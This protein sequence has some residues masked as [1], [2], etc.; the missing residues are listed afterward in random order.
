MAALAGLYG[1]RGAQ[2]LKAGC[3]AILDA[4]TPYGD[5]D[6]HIAAFEEVSLGLAS[7]EETPGGQPMFAADRWL[8]VADVRL[9]NRQDLEQRLDLEPTGSLSDREIIFQCWLRWGDR[10]AEYVSGEYAL[11]AFDRVE[12]KLVLAR[13]PTGQRPLYFI[14]RNGVIALASMPSGLAAIIGD[15]QPNIAQLVHDVALIPSE[16]D[17]TV[18][19]DIQRLL[20]AETIVFQRGSTSRREWSPRTQAILSGADD[21]FVEQFRFHLDEA[22]R[23]RLPRATTA[24][25]LSAGWDSNAVTATAAR[26]LKDPSGL[27]ALTSAPMAGPLGQLPRG[28]FADEAEMAGIAARYYGVRHVVVRETESD[29]SVMRRFT[30]LCQMPVHSPTQ[31]AWWSRLRHVARDSGASTILTGELGNWT[32]NFGGLA[33]LGDLARRGEWHR[34]WLEARKAARRHDVRWRGILINSFGYRLPD[35]L[36]DLLVRHFQRFEAASAVKFL[37]PEWRS[38]LHNSLAARVRANG[39]TAKDRWRQIKANDIGPWR[40]AGLA[41]CGVMESDPTADTRLIEFGLRLPS[42]QL[43]RNGQH[44]PLARKALT[45]RV[46]AAVLNARGRGMQSADWHLHSSQ[47]DAYAAL[48]DIRANNDAAQMF[49]LNEV[50]RAI[51]R[52]PTEDWNGAP[53]QTYSMDLPAVLATGIFLSQFNVWRPQDKSPRI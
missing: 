49:D 23:A 39:D 15:P 28:R 29:L 6:H 3:R 33:V 48:E 43:F 21:D 4:L 50:E 2:F 17:S 30:P 40:L 22:V 42:E 19:A 31:A 16:R 1:A 5:G 27:I 44:R 26:Q 10:F 9:A 8:M 37:R 32:L 36:R 46:P 38:S 13:D 35:F 47:A 41:D 18:F 12:Q 14:Q 52:W 20:P 25:H 51:A 34:W 11:A 7:D 45:D 24:T 53:R